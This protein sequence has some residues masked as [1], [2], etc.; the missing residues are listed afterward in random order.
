MRLSAAGNVEVPAFL[1]LA[2][3]GYAIK[4]TIA[5]DIEVW[6]AAKG[7]DEFQADSPLQLLGVVV[8]AEERG[9]AWAAED[10]QID[11]FLRR[12]KIDG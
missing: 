6:S 10:E 2:S 8:V 5:D 11:A 9:D 4:R 1:V 12:F 7:E 3:K